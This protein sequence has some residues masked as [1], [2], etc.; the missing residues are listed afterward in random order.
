MPAS[1]LTLTVQ[2]QEIF[3]RAHM[4][5][6]LRQL[7]SHS[8]GAIVD[9]NLIVHGIQLLCHAPQLGPLPSQRLQDWW[10]V[11]AASTGSRC[12]SA[13]MQASTMS[14][15]SAAGPRMPVQAVV[16]RV[17]Q[18]RCLHCHDLAADSSSLTALILA[19]TSCACLFA[20]STASS[21][22]PGAPWGWTAATAAWPLLATAGAGWSHFL[23]LRVGSTGMV[24]AV[25]TD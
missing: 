13:L 11:S 15:G 24:S 22:M 18:L 23:R 8:G 14:Q 19:T 1:G 5:G 3:S 7:I 10:G 12:D 4:Q 20:L 21:G 17:G 25:S 6:P 16:M 2:Q 9:H